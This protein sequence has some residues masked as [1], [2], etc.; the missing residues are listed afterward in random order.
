MKKKLLIIVSTL[1]MLLGVMTLYFQTKE[2]LLPFDDRQIICGLY[3]G[4]PEDSVN[5]VLEKNL[6]SKILNVFHFNSAD[7]SYQINTHSYYCIDFFDFENFKSTDKNTGHLGVLIPQFKN[8]KLERC[9]IVIGYYFTQEGKSSNLIFEQMVS[10]KQWNEILSSLSEK[11]G[12]AY[13][14]PIFSDDSNTDEQD[15]KTGIKNN[16][17]KFNYI[18]LEE[19]GEK[20]IPYDNLSTTYYKVNYPEL[21]IFTTVYGAVGAGYGWTIPNL[22]WNDNKK[23][24]DE[25][26]IKENRILTSADD[27]L[28]YPCITYAVDKKF[29]KSLGLEDPL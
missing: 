4:M 24:H 25:I 7:S 12:D 27:V 14:T 15:K 18:K 22:V 6:K 19:L 17:Y 28:S 23:G 5:Q 21:K 16:D 11:Y 26:N 13:G 8:K 2:D 20:F 9:N 29:Y 1:I 3:F 10:R